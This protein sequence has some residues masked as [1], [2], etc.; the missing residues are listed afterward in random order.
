MLLIKK[1]GSI[2]EHLP[3][4]LFILKVKKLYGDWFQQYLDKPEEDKLLILQPMDQRMG[5]RIR[6][7]LRKPNKP[8][9]I[10]RDDCIVIVQDKKHW[11]YWNWRHWN[12]RYYFMEKFGIDPPTINGDQMPFHRN[13]SSAQATLNFKN[14][15]S[16]VTENHHLYSKVGQ[17][18][19]FRH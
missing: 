8:C 7:S 10:S 12:W 14:N 5:T 9:F 4:S 19:H 18:S 11:R 17:T 1:A 6:V 16:F 13:E 3:K 15:E 2:I